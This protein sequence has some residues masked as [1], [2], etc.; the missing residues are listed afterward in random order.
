MPNMKNLVLLFYAFLSL[1]L[2]PTAQRLIPR[3]PVGRYGIERD[4]TPNE[5]W[6]HWSSFIP[7]VLDTNDNSEVPLGDNSVLTDGMLVSAAME[8]WTQ[9]NTVLRV[10]PYN[11]GPKTIPK[12]M[13]V[14][15]VPGQLFFSSSVKG[16]GAF[17]LKFQESCASAALQRCAS[18]TGGSHTNKGNCGEPSAV[19]LFCLKNPDK[20]GKVKN[21]EGLPQPARV[22]TVGVD[23]NFQNLAIKNPCGPPPGN[24]DPTKWGCDRF[25]SDVKVRAILSGTTTP[26]TVPTN[27][28]FEFSRVCLVEGLLRKR[29]SMPDGNDT[30]P[31]LDVRSLVMLAS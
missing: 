10:P 11:R 19:H 20:A 15:H 29:F 28:K 5:N 12:A 23:N 25:V 24:T 18:T 1:A 31:F 17:E 27:W 26:E 4:P 22:V 21:G 13:S 30:A 8:A 3:D 9:M 14:L 16:I 2:L 7:S 6:M